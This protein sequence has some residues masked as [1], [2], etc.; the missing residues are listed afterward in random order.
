MSKSCKNQYFVQQYPVACVHNYVLTCLGT[1][2]LFGCA[3]REILK[4][5]VSEINKDN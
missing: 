3:I 2:F 1:L 4:Y 5:S